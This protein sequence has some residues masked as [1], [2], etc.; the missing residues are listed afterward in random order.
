MHVSLTLKRRGAYTN[1]DFVE[2]NVHLDISSSETIENVT[3][4]VEGT[5]LLVT[6]FTIGIAKTTIY[7]K[8]PGSEKS[9]PKPIVEVHK[10]G[11]LWGQRL[12]NSYYICNR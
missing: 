1:L 6:K 12:M 11:D 8:K 3:V 5:T 7:A 10:V 9:K 2:G 4:K